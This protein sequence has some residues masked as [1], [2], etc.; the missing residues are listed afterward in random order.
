MSE[1]V[2]IGKYDVSKD[3]VYLYIQHFDRDKSDVFSWD[4]VRSEL[5]NR[6]FV[7]LGLTRFSADC[8]EFSEALEK[9]CAPKIEQYDALTARL[10]EYAVAKTPQDIMFTKMKVEQ[11]IVRQEFMKRR[12]IV[13]KPSN[14][15]RRCGKDL[16][17]GVARINDHMVTLSN[18][19]TKDK[20][21]C[22]TCS[23]KNP[24]D[25]HIAFKKQ[26]WS[27]E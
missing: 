18:G 9:F 11:E 25:Y 7:N 27:Q 26:Y 16:P 8:E 10:K 20:P 23:D 5:H 14:E 24:D 15:C 19:E 3:D 17:H 22:S 13:Q 12:G 2:R 4:K 1:T 21:I 6:I